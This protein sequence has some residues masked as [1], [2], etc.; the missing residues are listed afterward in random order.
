MYG[1]YDHAVGTFCFVL[2][3]LLA[4]SEQRCKEPSFSLFPDVGMVSGTYTEVP[5]E[6]HIKN[7]YLPVVWLLHLLLIPNSAL[8]GLTF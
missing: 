6:M 8:A 1:D 5:L 7:E 4:F 2:C 3:L